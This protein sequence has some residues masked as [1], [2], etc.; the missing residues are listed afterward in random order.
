MKQS[1][2]LLAAVL[3][4]GAVS[5]S[6]AQL[7]PHKGQGCE[8]CSPKVTT[9][10]VKKRLYEAQCKK[11]CVP[12]FRWPWQKCDGEVGRVRTIHKLAIRIRTTEKPALDWKSP[13]ICAPCV[14]QAH[15]PGCGCPQCR[16]R[17]QYPIQSL[18]SQGHPRVQPQSGSYV[19]KLILPQRLV[20]PVLEIRE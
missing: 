14:E 12:R 6:Q 20:T 7:L 16:D 1:M 11:V 15:E 17:V 9:K 5:D 13:E 19:P 8:V 2:M 10:K 18:S 3:L 4:A